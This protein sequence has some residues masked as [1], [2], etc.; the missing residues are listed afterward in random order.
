MAFELDIQGQ[1]VGEKG[2]HQEKKV[3]IRESNKSDAT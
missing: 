1:V 3:V 2:L